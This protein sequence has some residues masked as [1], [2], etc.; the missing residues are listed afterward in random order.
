MIKPGDKIEHKEYGT[1]TVRVV[2]NGGMIEVEFDKP[3]FH[4]NRVLTVQVRNCR[5]I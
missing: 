1:G 2:Y 3:I 4:G 5:R